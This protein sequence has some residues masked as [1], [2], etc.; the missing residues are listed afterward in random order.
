MLGQEVVREEQ[1]ERL[2]GRFLS[3]EGAHQVPT[4]S[5][6]WDKPQWDFPAEL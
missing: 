4:A 1:G 3:S 2:E 6:P 5:A